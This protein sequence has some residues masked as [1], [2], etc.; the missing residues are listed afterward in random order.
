MA[1]KSNKT[2]NQPEEK[3]EAKPEEQPKEK[4]VVAAPAFVAAPAL[5]I[6]RAQ[7]I[8]ITD[9]PKPNCHYCVYRAPGVVV[10]VDEAMEA[11]RAAFP[12]TRFTYFATR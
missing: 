12:Q 3:P 11:L 1:T 4:P 8:E 9:P 2:A 5:V 7:G 10:D 6:E